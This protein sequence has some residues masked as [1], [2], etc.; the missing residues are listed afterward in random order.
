GGLYGHGLAVPVAGTE[1]PLIHGFDGLLIQT[2]AQAAYDL[3]IPRAPRGVHYQL[4]DHRAG[5]FGFARL[6]GILGIDFGEHHRSRDAAADTEHA[7]ANAAAFTRS[8]TA[9]FT[10]TDAATRPAS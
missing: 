6:F 10:G 4:Q 7:A 5:V 1:L 3:D 8:K 9:A 2:E